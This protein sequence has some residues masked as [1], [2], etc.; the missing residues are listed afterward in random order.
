MDDDGESV[1]ITFGDLPAGV[2][3]GTKDNTTVS[4]TDDDHPADVSVSFEQDTY[5]AT[6]GESV[7]VKLTLSQAPERAVT[8]HLDTTAQG[9]AVEDDYSGVP[10]MVSF[11]AEETEKT[12][13]FEAAQDSEDDDDESVRVAL[14]TLPAGLSEGTNAT[15][16]IEITDDD[17]P[18]VTVSFEHATYTALESDDPTTTEVQENTAAIKVKLSADPERTMTIPITRGDQEEA[19]NQDPSNQASNQDYSGVP[20]SLTFNAGETEK[21]ITFVATHDGMDEEESVKLGFGPNLPAGVSKSGTTETTVSI[22]DD[23]TAGITVDPTSLT[24]LEDGTNTY[25][26]V[27]DS[28]PAQTVTVTIN[29]PADNTDVTADPANLAFTTG[30]WSTPQTVTVTAAQDDNAD[31]ETPTITHDVAGYA[32]VATAD[33]VTVTVT[34]DAPDSLTVRFEQTTYTVDEGDSVTVKVKLDTDPK[35]T[36]TVP[37]NKDNQ[38]GATSNDYSGVPTQ[39]TFLRGDTEKVIPFL[40][41]DDSYNDDGES[42]KL[43]FGPM[44]TGVN[45]GTTNEATVNITDDDVPSINV[46]FERSQYT[47]LESDDTSTTGVKEN[48]VTIKVVLSADPERTV[49]IQITK[50]DQD[51]ATPADY[52]GV[53]ASVEFASGETEQTITFAAVNDSDNDDGE[54]VKLGFG[55]L[56][57]GVSAGTNNETVISITDD[58][59]TPVEVSFEQAEYTVAEGSSVTVKVKLNQ[60]TERTVVIPI[61]KAN[62]DG[63]SSADYTG[64]PTSVEFSSGDTEKS[65]TFD[66]ENDSEDDDGESVKLGFGNTLPDGVS[67]SGTTEATVNITDDDVPSVSVSFEHETYTVEEGDSVMVKVKLDAD[68]ERT[69]SIPITKAEQ[70][71][72]ADSDY[73]IAPSSVTF[74]SGDT[75]KN[76]TFAAVDDDIDDDGESVK[77]SFGTMPTGVSAGTTPESTVNITDDDVPSV[78]VSFEQATY[79]VAESDSV[80]VKVKLNVAPERT[81]IIPITKANQGGASNSDYSG[82]PENVTFNSNDT[83]KTF[84]FSATTDSHNDDGESVR[85]GFGTNLPTGVAAGTTNETVVSITDDD[86]PTLTVS[87]EQPTYTVQE[88][89]DTSTTDVKENEVTVKVT[90]SAAPE[91]RVLINLNRNDEG[92]ATQADYEFVPACFCV[93]FA[94]SET[95]DTITFTIKH[96]TI[97]DDGESV[98]I[99]M[100]SLPDGVN[101]GTNSETTVNIRDDDTADLL[102]LP[103]S[104]DIDE[105]DSATFTVKL[106]AGRP[107]QWRAVASGDAGAATVS[108]TSLSFSTTTW[109]DAQTV[110]VSGENDADGNNESLTVSLAASS[111]DAGYN[112][113]TASVSVSITDDDTAGRGDDQSHPPERR[114]GRDSHLHRGAGHGTHGRGEGNHRGP[115]RQH[116]CYRR[117]GQPSLHHEQLGYRPDCNGNGGP[118]RRRRGRDGNH[119]PHGYGIRDGYHGGR[120]YSRRGGRRPGLPGGEFRAGFLHSGRGEQRHS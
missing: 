48:E 118:G 32:T 69:V 93:D 38:G 43:G 25:T 81:V 67:A 44:P 17:D 119:H 117:A 51:G 95:Q 110:T 105:G 87:F 100:A 22:T 37:I 65:I 19:N 64:V 78:N 33:D 34:D 113:K 20:E 4:I 77:L 79:T 74:D 75:E 3:P 97:D 11:A 29:D 16:V 23:D 103:S 35:R 85:L 62:Q 70:D 50:A 12:F 1:T 39:V 53:P 58:E 86:V 88:S 68:P 98:R 109:N 60:D 55:N 92:G 120:R 49:T 114:R 73:S 40:A 99:T 108:L 24:V 59:L 61:T 36:V 31:D 8:V 2:N 94:S 72:A 7:E 18:T 90:L 56:P 6:E 5:T 41:A 104:L 102:V 27:L 47:A 83:E 112:S 115:H 66:A 15:T 42:V 71:G 101:S 21:T 116:R 106:T 82:V 107:S 46:N 76:I 10:D 52:S 63:A 54:S 96:D 9:G 13:T 14:H 30:N 57:D 84:S 45:A 89:D 26:L 80:T 111:G 28:Q 91:R